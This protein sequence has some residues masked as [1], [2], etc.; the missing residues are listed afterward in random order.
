[1]EIKDYYNK[2]EELLFSIVNLDKDYSFNIKEIRELDIEVNKEGS[3]KYSIIYMLGVE[4]SVNY[5]RVS[6]IV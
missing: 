6:K 2:L 1:M 4:V 5:R 3:D